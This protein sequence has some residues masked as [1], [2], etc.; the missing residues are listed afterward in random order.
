MLL[1]AADGSEYN[2]HDF[3]HHVL[4]VF[5]YSVPSHCFVSK[6]S[7]AISYEKVRNFLRCREDYIELQM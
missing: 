3:N 4:G 2:V 5:G 6:K 7:V 1:S